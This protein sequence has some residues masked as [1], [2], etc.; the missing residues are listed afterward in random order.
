[1]EW[2]I[3]MKTSLG[4]PEL[5]VAAS[6]ADSLLCAWELTLIRLDMAPDI[7]RVYGSAHSINRAGDLD[8]TACT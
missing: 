1:M 5:T 3:D 2:A 6:S 4:Y 7:I 8:K